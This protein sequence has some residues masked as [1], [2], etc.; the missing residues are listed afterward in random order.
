MSDCTSVLPPRAA[1]RLLGLSLRTLERLRASGTG[2][3]HT[4][5]GDRRIGYR[6]DELLAWLDARTQPQRAI[7]AERGAA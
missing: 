7:Q 4:R 1:A 6:K 5:L 2:P 3:R